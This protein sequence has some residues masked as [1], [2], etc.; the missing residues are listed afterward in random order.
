MVK[1]SSTS[2]HAFSSFLAEMVVLIVDDSNVMRRLV[3]SHLTKLGVG[4]IHQAN[5]G[6]NALEFIA[7]AEIDLVVSD[8]SM[9]N[10]T[11]IQFLT[12][13]RKSER[14]KNIPFI[15][16]TAEAQLYNIHSAFKLRV[17]EYITKPFTLDYF[18][19]IVKKVVQDKY[20]A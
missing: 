9:P 11:G 7:T 12:E 17:D 10:I 19:F 20:L 5:S 16:L 15:L 18:N 1:D 6:K 14:N 3:S 2:I 8:W 13:L 4:Q